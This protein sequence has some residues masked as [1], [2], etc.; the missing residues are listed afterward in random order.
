MD[1]YVERQ[2]I[3]QMKEGNFKQFIL[4]FDANFRDLY[5]YVFRRVPDFQEADR[6]TR[7]TFFDALG[8]VQ[9]TPTDTSFLVWLYCLARPR[10]FAYLNKASFPEKQGLMEKKEK[11]PAESALNE[12]ENLVDRAEKMMAKMTLEEREILRLK[13]FEQVADGDVMTVLDIN[14][15]SIGTKIYRVLKRA[16]FLLF[17]ESDERKGVYFGELSSFMEKVRELEDVEIPEV[18]ALTLKNEL[19]MRI[20]RKD[21]AIESEAVLE[22]PGF[23]TEEP[24]GEPFVVKGSDDPAKIFVEAVK[25]MK[26]QEVL[27]KIKKER[28][29]ERREKLIEFFEQW[30]R[31]F[32]YIPAVLFV[33][34]VAIVIIR[35]YGNLP[36]ERGYVTSCGIE[37]NL[38]GDFSDAETRSVHLGISDRICGHFEDVESLTISRTEEGK[39]SVE[40]SR[41]E[42]Y[43][44]YDFVKKIK[45]WK[46]KKYARTFSGDN[47]SGEV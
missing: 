4:L 7:M 31:V 46:I 28:S 34:A 17:G 47:E 37:V 6:I 11:K 19:V 25:E 44:E 30:K 12:E 22:K 16:H 18:L 24:F 10:V 23:E 27:S 15:G 39:V 9:N 8:Q 29:E 14:E 3:E 21:F 35:W 1:L 41:K 13:F 40:V 45:N 42:W 2:C 32:I 43:L 20:D 33:F 38:D 26:E 5:K 36:V